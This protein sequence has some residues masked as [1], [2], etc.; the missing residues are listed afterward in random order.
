MP[1]FSED[2]KDYSMATK[3]SQV[4]NARY[5]MLDAAH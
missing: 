3:L 2:V 4:A 5:A 1:F